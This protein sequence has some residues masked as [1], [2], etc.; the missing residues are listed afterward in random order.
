MILPHH[1]AS[2][3]D[4]QVRRQLT[5]GLLCSSGHC[6]SP[7]SPCIYGEA[8]LFDDL[9][10]SALDG[11]HPLHLL[12][13]TVAHVPDACTTGRQ[14]DA[15]DSASDL[16][17]RADVCDLAEINNTPGLGGRRDI[18]RGKTEQVPLL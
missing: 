15:V 8:D 4:E 9:G 6:Q 12:C 7:V 1:Q 10:N 18:S 17:S 11:R 2:L 13:L 16:P 5:E 14:L 3:T